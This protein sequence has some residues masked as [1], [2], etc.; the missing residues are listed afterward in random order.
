M[1]TIILGRTGLRVTVAGLGCG[2]FSR[3]GITKGEAHAAGIARAAYDAGVTFFDTAT[4]YGT[5][6]ALGQG[7]SGIK[8]DSYV[9]S[10]KFPYRGRDGVLGADD[11][12]NTLEN[13]L[14]ALQTDYIDVYHIHAVT[15]A[16]YPYVRDTLLPE[17]Q[18]AQQLGKIRF[19]GVTEQF[20]VDTAHEML[21]IALPENLFDVVM[22]GY[23]ILNPSAARRVL[24]TAI[25]NNVAVLCMFA[26]R[27]A[28]HDPEQLKTDLA[29][30]IERGQC[31]DAL[32]QALQAVPDGDRSRVLD[33]LLSPEAAAS[34]TEAA[35]RFARHT[36]GITVTLTGTG[37]REHLL[38]N[39]ASLSLPPLPSDALEQL[40]ALFG[41]VDCVSGQ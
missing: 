14:R 39:L 40:N 1:D 32:N 37:N 35:Y 13:S 15:A 28:L 4:A 31:A 11:L 8:R 6:T 25:A 20:A 34:L 16:D 9:L 30:I 3:I 23:N 22:T 7:L 21:Q 27:R 24:P 38:Q 19:L 36:P 2:G 26:V 33:F 17:M 12:R 29:R 10:T 41:S 18:R 5:E